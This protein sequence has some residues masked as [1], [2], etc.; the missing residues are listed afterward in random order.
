MI[1]PFLVIGLAALFALP[2]HASEDAE[3]IASVE[4]GKQQFMKQARQV[5]RDLSK[6]DK[7]V[8]LK[9]DDRKRVLAALDRM[10]KALKPVE[11]LEQ[12]HEQDRVALFNDQELVNTLLTEAREDSRQI[13]RREKSVGSNMARLS[14]ETVAERRRRISAESRELDRQLDIGRGSDN[15]SRQIREG[16]L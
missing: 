14:C 7:Y 2:V 10:Q 8:E 13:C 5:R 3:N 9:Q 16:T 11:S 1:R 4:S 6:S 12:L 15:V